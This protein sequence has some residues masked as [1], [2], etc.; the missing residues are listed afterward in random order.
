MIFQDPLSSLT[1]V[2][3]VG[4]PD[5]R[6]AA[7]PPGPGRA[8]AW[9]RAVEL[10][11]LVG[12]PNARP[13]GPVVPARVLRRHAPAGR[14][15][16]GDR[17][18]P[19]VI[20]AD[21]P[22][23]ALDVTV[24][25]QILEVLKT[26]QAETG[27]AIVLIT[28]D[29]GVVAGFADRVLV[30]YAG[31]PVE[32]GAVDDMFYRGRGCRTRSGCSA[33]CRAGRAARPAA[34]PDRGQPAVAG[35]PAAGLPVRAPLPALDRPCTRPSRRSPRC[36]TSAHRAACIRADEIEDGRIDG[37]D[38]FPPPGARWWSHRGSRADQRPAVLELTDLSQALPAAQGWCSSAAVARFTRSTASLR[39]PGGRD[40]RAG[41]RVR[42]RQDHD[43]ARDLNLEPPRA[44]TIRI[45]AVDV[46][47]CAA[48][49]QGAAPP[50]AD[51]VPGPDGVAG[52]AAAVGD[53][54]AE[55]LRA[56]GVPTAPRSPRRVDE[57]LELVGLTPSTATASRTEFSG[58]Q[59]Q[60]IGIARAL[61]T[62]PKLLVLDEPVSALDVSI[63]AGVINLLNELKA[64]LGLSYLFVAH[65]LSVVRHIA[66]RVAVMYLGRIVEVGPVDEVFDR[67]VAPVHP[68]AA[69][70]DPGARPA[71][72]AHPRAVLLRG[73]LPTS[74]TAAA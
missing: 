12:I 26:A 46:A 44:G 22:T 48:A 56:F 54:L 13:A 62:E 23:T 8:A 6:G 4:R 66:D 55:P 68:G 57:L 33:R 74:G 38:V 24:Q 36:G 37:A 70:G 27:A 35:Q 59:R 60:R 69:V 21:E 9:K 29:L 1:P 16:D 5:R 43:A 52:P 20:I 19:D 50:A 65:D 51:R 58:G 31:R 53:I 28:H 47:G 11:D 63:Q 7:D 10:L 39:H 15:R 25:A 71:G 34:D 14:D 18:R 45:S 30:M 2:Y 61:A 67:A 41:R 3:T 64:E 40:A 73:D 49:T 42:V 72:R 32:S 17:Q